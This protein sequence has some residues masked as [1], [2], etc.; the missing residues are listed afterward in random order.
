M[1]NSTCGSTR[2]SRKSIPLQPH[3]LRSSGRR[4]WDVADPSDCTRASPSK[5]LDPHWVSAVPPPMDSSDV[6]HDLASPS[7][8]LCDGELT[9]VEEFAS[10]PM[11]EESTIANPVHLARHQACLEDLRALASRPILAFEAVAPALEA[12][13][14]TQDGAWCLSALVSID[15]M[16]RSTPASANA[17][18]RLDGWALWFARALVRSLS[19]ASNLRRSSQL[20]SNDSHAAPSS[21]SKEAASSTSSADSQAAATD[22]IEAQDWDACAH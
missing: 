4:I 14:N 16:I 2:N 11:N 6:T 13:C 19:M 10:E 7:M 20:Q 1:V 15:S 22:A 8:W 21:D 3:M 5:V 17:M 18:L 9:E 12:I